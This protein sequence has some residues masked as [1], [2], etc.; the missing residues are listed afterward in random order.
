[1]L[2]IDTNVLVRLLVRDDPAQFACA[3]DMIKQE[4]AQ[5]HPVLIN[6]SV[7]L[8][9]V[10]VLQSRYKLDKARLVAMLSGLLAVDDVRLEDEASVESALFLWKNA[11]AGFADCLISSKNQRLGCRATATFDVKAARVVGFVPVVALD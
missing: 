7:L 11:N 10:W 5:G 3:F 6:H 1:M 4:L 2:G 9:T 8:E